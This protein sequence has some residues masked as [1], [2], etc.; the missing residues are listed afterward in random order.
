VP[1]LKDERRLLW[2]RVHR[3]LAR[4]PVREFVEQRFSRGSLEYLELDKREAAY[5][6]KE[7]AEK[8]R[9]AA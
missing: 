4:A 8:K 9:T 1:T 5:Q 3:P 7:L 6:R 2:L